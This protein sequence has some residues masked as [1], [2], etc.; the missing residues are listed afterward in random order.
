MDGSGGQKETRERSYS[1]APSRTSTPGTANT[2]M[3]PKSANSS[4][5]HLRD[6]SHTGS[7]PTHKHH[8]SQCGRIPGST[9]PMLSGGAGDELRRSVAAASSLLQERLQQERNERRMSRQGTDLI[10]PIGDIRDRGVHD[11]AVRRSA[12]AT[13]RRQMPDSALSDEQIKDTGM[14]ARQTEQTLSKLHTQNFD[15]KLELYYRREKQVALE[16]RIEKLETQFSE[17]IDSNSKLQSQYQQLEKRY[18]EAMEINDSML[19][20][21]E[22]K[23]QA[24]GDAAGVIIASEA[25]IEE[26]KRERDMVR[27]VE[28]DGSYRHSPS[29]APNPEPAMTAAS[30]PTNLGVSPLP[31]DI[32]SLTR[33]SSF[34]SDHSQQTENLRNAVLKARNSGMHLRKVSGSSADPSE[35]NRLA[36]PSLSILS[37]SS[38]PSIYGVK[39]AEDK[40]EDRR[41]GGMATMDGSQ[42]DRSPTPTKNTSRQSWAGQMPVGNHGGGANLS[43][44]MQSLNNV[45]DMNSPLQ[46]IERLEGQMG[47]V[48]DI[49]RQPISDRSRGASTPTSARPSINPPQQSK[50]KQEKREALQKVLTNYPTHRDFSN[51][52][53]FPP[54]PDTV[55][56]STLRK[57]QTFT[58]SQD[59]LTKQTGTVQAEG[60]LPMYDRIAAARESTYYVTSNQQVSATASSGRTQMPLSATSANPF[61]DLGQLARSIPARTRSASETESSRAR[62]ASVGSDSDSDGGADARSE[63]ASV[64]YWMRESMKPNRYQTK[65][66]T[67]REGGGSVSPDLFSFPAEG[68]GWETDAIFGA[69]KGSGYLGAPISALKRD[70]LDEMASSLQTPQA[71]VFEPPMTGAAPPTPDRRSSLHAL[72]GSTNVVPPA[73]SRLRKSLAKGPGMGWMDGRG[74]SNSV[75]TAAQALSSRAQPQPEATMSGKR[76]HYP[77]ISG[78]TSKGRGLGLNSFFRRS[79]SGSESFSV[80]SSATETTFP[81]PTPA[82]LPALP[83]TMNFSKPSGRNSVPPPATMPW[84]PPGVVEDHFKSATPPPIMRSRGQSLLSATGGARIID[85]TTP[86]YQGT[87]MAVPATPTTVVPAQGGSV[88]STP[89]GAGRRKWLGLGRM[90]SN[91][92]K[93]G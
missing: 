62:A 24:I 68:G 86:Q 30:K 39:D 33:M 88:N 72:T 85:P 48:D 81:I 14:G 80:P 87:E 11:S 44:Q 51:P 66:S 21:M 17:L 57:H 90:G 64:D 84:R 59:S 3:T 40:S 19:V 5:S 74:R 12:T 23:D 56:S 32:K 54:T 73:G 42:V 20:E 22:R 13:G 1:R 7:Y 69:L 27:R 28:A 10:T 9:R 18:R 41:S 82:Q 77:P 76:N 36:S 46:K 31:G 4:S 49:L 37:E 93:M 38:F 65:F 45:L 75:D 78:Q 15:L 26:L 6:T 63:T 58:S 53:A 2:H 91:K 55:S 70:P 16:E 60:L 8:H 83:P 52:Q 71:E 25:Y 79:G 29:N 50:S 67:Q 35:I 89:N 34:L 61:P 47:V 43:N 92:N